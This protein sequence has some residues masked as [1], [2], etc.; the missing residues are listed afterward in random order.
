[1]SKGTSS[2]SR[3]GPDSGSPSP[4]GTVSTD[5]VKDPL[6]AW[7]DLEPTNSPR[8]LVPSSIARVEVGDCLTDE[9]WVQR[10]AWTSDHQKVIHDR[11]LPKPARTETNF[12]HKQQLPGLADATEDGRLR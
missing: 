2:R 1:M 5:A 6:L 3:A 9:D 4:P 8:P 10:P 12:T 11:S 7:R